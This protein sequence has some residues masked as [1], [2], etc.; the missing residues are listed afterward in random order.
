MPFV[1]VVT[2]LNNDQCQHGWQMRISIDPNA[3]HSGNPN[4]KIEVIKSILRDKLKNFPA[5]AKIYVLENDAEFYDQCDG[6]TSNA[7]LDRD[8]RGKEICIYLNDSNQQ[9]PTLEEYK[10]LILSLWQG[11]QEAGV[12]LL[13]IENPGDRKILGPLGLYTPFSFT[14][15]EERCEWND[16]HG[17][18]FKQFVG[19][20]NNH[21][22]LQVEFTEQDLRNGDVSFN[23]NEI[24]ANTRAYIPAHQQSAKGR[25]QFEMSDLT[26]QGRTYREDLFNDVFIKTIRE[27]LEEYYTQFPT[28]PFAE[29]AAYQIHFD[30]ELKRFPAY[31]RLVEDYPHEPSSRFPALG[32]I[33]GALGRCQNIT[34]EQFDQIIGQ[35]RNEYDNRLNDI[36]NDFA[37]HVNAN[38]QLLPVGNLQLPPT[39]QLQKNIAINW[40]EY[41]PGQNVE[42]LIELNPQR[43]QVMYR[44]IV[45]LEREKQAYQAYNDRCAAGPVINITPDA[46]V[47]ALKKEFVKALSGIQTYI[48]R[49]REVFSFQTHL[50]FFARV[51]QNGRGLKRAQVYQ[52]ILSNDNYSLK[53]KAL[54]LYALLA[55]T[56][57]IQLKEDVAEAI[58]GPGN[59]NVS[60]ARAQISRLVQTVCQSDQNRQR[61][62]EIVRD[63]VNYANSATVGNATDIPPSTWNGI[64]DVVPLPSPRQ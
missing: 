37:I 4:N 52:D 30:E 20:D 18:V 22:I 25:L 24:I 63:I 43:M 5:D 40:N 34:L 14:S 13:Y 3:L 2:K 35:L 60:E 57:G 15:Q 8:Q 19:Y 32:C 54:T 36:K 1:P 31:K 61:H 6:T 26:K 12:P 9:Q 21:P 41:F 42:R 49:P 29:R 45:F 53:Q 62:N 11:L 39:P 47:A 27:K 50:G 17:L 46:N 51:F 48:T 44:R 16:K 56:N 55:T 64:N 28:L 23:S 33:S 10:K 58:L 7:G 38:S 59:R